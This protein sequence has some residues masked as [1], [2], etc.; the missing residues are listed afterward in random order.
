MTGTVIRRGTNSFRL[1]VSAG[2]DGNK[3]R[4]RLTRTVKASSPKEAEKQLALFIAEIEKGNLAQSKGMTVS[5]LWDYWK[6]NYASQNLETTSLVF[7][8]N[9]WPRIKTALGNIR[10][11]R[12]E[13]KHVQCFYMNLQEIGV[14]HVQQTKSDAKE[15]KEKPLKSLSATT[16]RQYHTV[17][18]ALF[19]RAVKWGFMNYNICER[20]TPP[21]AAT[22]EKEVYSIEQTGSFLAAM[23]SEETHHRLQVMLALTTGLRNEELFGLRWSDIEGNILHVRQCRIYLGAKHGVVTKVPKNKGSRRDL[24]IDEE[25][26]ALLKKHKAE[27]SAKRLKLGNLWK[28]SDLVFTTWNGADGHPQSF[29]TYLARFTNKNDLPPISPHNFRHM[30]ATYLINK[31]TDIRTVSGK[32][33]H[34]KSSTTMNIYSHLLIKAETA[35]ATT[36]TGILAEARQSHQDKKK[37]GTK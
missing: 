6:T 1:M 18:S 2:F 16:V 30:A 5:Q 23:E 17:L 26:S 27:E 7:Y 37:T 28:G 35:T 9:K 21:K 15:G 36:M 4:Q 14:K 29:R 31:G 33:G 8:E 20:C 3:K 34:S 22:I 25:V 10:L 19:S 11:D 13:P 12:L 32:L 24:T